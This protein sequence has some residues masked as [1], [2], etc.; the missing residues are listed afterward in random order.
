MTCKIPRLTNGVF[1]GSERQIPRTHRYNGE[2]RPWGNE[3][4]K[5]PAI[6]SDVHAFFFEQCIT[7]IVTP[8]KGVEVNNYNVDC[9][10][11]RAVPMEK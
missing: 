5:D 2:R 9:E 11:Q 8:S 1:G 10:W 7:Q 6:G 3:T 4:V